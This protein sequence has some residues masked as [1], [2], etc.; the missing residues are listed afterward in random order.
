MAFVS[1][2]E[3]HW[4][5]R[6]FMLGMTKREVLDVIKE[7]GIHHKTFWKRFGVNTCALD[8]SGEILYYGCDIRTALRCCYENRGK[9]LWEWD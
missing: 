6:R 8:E 4:F 5:K 1:V 7:L 2:F 9:Y 3:K